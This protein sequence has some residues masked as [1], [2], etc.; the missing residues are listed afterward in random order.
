MKTKRSTENNCW[1]GGTFEKCAP[2]GTVAP[3]APTLAIDC[4]TW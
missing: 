4:Y 2:G 1:R 3:Y